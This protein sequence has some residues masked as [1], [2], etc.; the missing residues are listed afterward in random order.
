MIFLYQT[1]L[2]KAEGGYAVGANGEELRLIGPFQIR[3][4]QR[5]W[6]DGK[7]IFGY[8]RPKSSEFVFP[9]LDSGI[10]VLCDNR[11][12]Y[13]TKKG[14][15]KNYPVAE[16][17]FI[18][19]NKNIFFGGDNVN[20]QGEKI[21]DAVINDDGEIFSVRWYSPIGWTISILADLTKFLSYWKIK[22]YKN[23]SMIQMLNIC[24]ICLDIYSFCENFRPSY[25]Y[26]SASVLTELLSVTIDKNGNLDFFIFASACV[27]RYKFSS[28]STIEWISACGL[29]H[30]NN[31]D[32]QRLF[33]Q[34]CNGGEA[35]RTGE[36]NFAQNIGDGSY[37]MNKFGQMTFRDSDKNILAENIP[38]HDDFCYGETNS[39]FVDTLTTSTVNYT[40][41]TSDGN[42][43]SLT[44]N[45]FNIVKFDPFYKTTS[46][47]HAQNFFGL[48]TDTKNFYNAFML[49]PIIKKL[50]DGKYLFG[51]HGGKLY[52][53]TADN[54]QEVGNNF[55]NFRLEEL[56]NI[57]KAKESET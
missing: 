5:V 45:I 39:Y 25:N 34:T 41:Y 54:I 12:G 18:V 20:Q 17:D 16:H 50:S 32:I 51:N 33:L 53:K 9:T 57:K 13:F 29:Y 44:R 3:V 48:L 26:G 22:L 40:L 31:G 49:K 1:V 21:F 46:S 6:T 38:I 52:L 36:I 10:P 14:V 43:Q 28:G 37:T 47:A 56:K 19:N 2:K 7:V 4:G 23:D 55:K 8:V 15:W 30:Y 27:W 42:S 35:T 24:D 11:K